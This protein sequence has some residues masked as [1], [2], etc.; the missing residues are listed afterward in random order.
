[1]GLARLDVTLAEGNWQVT[2]RWSSKAL[3]P[4]FND[5]V[6]HQGFLYGF[7]QNILACISAEDGTKRWKNGRFGFGQLLL[8]EADDRLIVTSE[9]GDLILLETNPDRLVE[10]GRVT[11]SPEKTWNHSIV[12]GQTLYF[13]NGAE[14]VAYQ[15]AP[16]A[17]AV[18][19]ATGE[20]S[21][22]APATPAGTSPETSSPPE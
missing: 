3:K 2:E 10:L 16:A 6:F 21:P 18:A 20:D 22:A 17:T 12:A 1:V 5:F 7:D 11:A 15:L 4:S 13:R 19:T 9:G 14:M 8:L